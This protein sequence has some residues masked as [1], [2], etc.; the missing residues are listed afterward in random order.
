VGPALRVPGVVMLSPC[1]GYDPRGL[2]VVTWGALLR[3]TWQ[4]WEAYTDESYA[5]ISN[6]YL[7]NAKKTPSGFDMAQLQADLKDISG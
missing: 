1:V 2:T 5:I 6:D 4:F 7:T 3:M